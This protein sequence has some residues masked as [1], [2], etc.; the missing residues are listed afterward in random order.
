MDTHPEESLTSAEV[1]W[2][3]GVRARTEEAARREHFLALL[4]EAEAAHPYALT[5]VGRRRLASAGHRRPTPEG[6]VSES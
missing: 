2:R 5:V 4:E 1:V 3:R 6:G